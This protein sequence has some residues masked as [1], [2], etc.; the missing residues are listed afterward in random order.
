MSEPMNQV[1]FPCMR[2]LQR[3]TKSVDA[4]YKVKPKPMT[5]RNMTRAS[6]A[7]IRGRGLGSLGS[8]RGGE[9]NR[10]DSRALYGNFNLRF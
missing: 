1:E 9:R 4:V 6:I 7:L 10:G 5:S 8:E 2:C 3:H